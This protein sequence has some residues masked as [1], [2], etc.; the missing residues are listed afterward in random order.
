[1]RV[2]YHFERS[3]RHPIHKSGGTPSP[4]VLSRIASTIVH[5]R[6]NERGG[7]GILVAIPV[8]IFETDPETSRALDNALTRAGIKHVSRLVRL[9]NE[10][11]PPPVEHF[12]ADLDLYH[13]LILATSWCEIGTIVRFAERT[14][15]KPRPIE[16]WIISS[17]STQTLEDHKAHTWADEILHRPISEIDFAMNVERRL[18]SLKVLELV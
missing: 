10:H 18:K 11:A 16:K 4:M 8:L 6:G 12:Q 2:S 14:M 17:Y 1:M 9:R 7:R 3:N 13:P 5:C 15:T